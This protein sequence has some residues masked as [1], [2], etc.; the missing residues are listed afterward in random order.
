MK[1]IFIFFANK[2]GYP[3]CG[4]ERGGLSVHALLSRLA[5]RAHSLVLILQNTQHVIDRG[6]VQTD[7]RVM[8]CRQ[9]I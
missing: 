7:T 8:R 3:P 9:F 6:E 1:Y 4:A 2:G 5:I